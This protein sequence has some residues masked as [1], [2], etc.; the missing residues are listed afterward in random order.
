MHKSIYGSAN[1][2][3]HHFLGSAWN[4]CHSNTRLALHG[5]MLWSFQD[6]LYARVGKEFQ[7]D[8]SACA[9]KNTSYTERSLNG[10]PYPF[11]V[12]TAISQC[13]FLRHYH[14]HYPNIIHFSILIIS[15]TRPYV[16]ITHLMLLSLSTASDTRICLPAGFCQAGVRTSHQKVTYW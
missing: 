15:Q 6:M 4:T 14:S 5:I 10:R 11:S 2:I 9:E 13:L 12:S 16:T 3:W 8:Q 1:K 7:G